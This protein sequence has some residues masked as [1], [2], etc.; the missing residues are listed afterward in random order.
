M[1]SL[2]PALRSPF[3]LFTFNTQ[4]EQ[5]E[6]IFLETIPHAI[7]AFT[8]AVFLSEFHHNMINLWC[9]SCSAAC[10]QLKHH[11]YFAYLFI[12]ISGQNRQLHRVS[13]Y[14]WDSVLAF[15]NSVEKTGLYGPL[16][17]CFLRFFLAV[18]WHN[19][20]CIK[21]L[22]QMGKKKPKKKSAGFWIGL[23]R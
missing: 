6:V 15:G 23:T 12:L 13:L 11:A 2:I 17:S 1:L 18:Y 22:I 9:L 7:T 8:M 14:F 5:L 19:Y 10:I 20:F 4:P 3:P 16:F 21:E